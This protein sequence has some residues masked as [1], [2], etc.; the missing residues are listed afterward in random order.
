MAVEE[1][2]PTARVNVAMK[3]KPRA[4]ANWRRAR[5][6]SVSI[7]WVGCRLTTHLE[8][9]GYRKNRISLGRGHPL[10]DLPAGWD[11]RACCRNVRGSVLHL[12]LLAGPPLEGGETFLAQ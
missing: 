10:D 6:R 4:L 2:M 1:P 12:V 8:K 7:R 11:R 3:A 9:R 5:R